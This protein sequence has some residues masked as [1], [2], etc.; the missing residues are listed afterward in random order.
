MNSTLVF[1]VG[2]VVSLVG[3]VPPG[4]L[5]MSAAKI[6]LKEGYSRGLMFSVGVCI[7]VALQAYIALIFARYLS[8]HPSSI[9]T[10]KRVAL[11]IFVLITIYYLF[12]AKRRLK[13]DLDTTVRS[14]KSR[15]FLGLFMSSINMFPIPYQAY[16][17]ISLASFNILTFSQATI[18]TYVLGAFSGTFAMLYMY[19]VFFEKVKTKN[20]TSQKNMNYL[21]GS[22]TGI[23]SIITFISIL[24]NVLQ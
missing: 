19:M 4:L 1:F 2:F 21:I 3:V 12:I 10:L 11:V 24:K 7:I 15:F 9:E 14:K 6:S 8:N 13:P 5:N 23:I 16:M 18:T 20:F 22:I 17:G